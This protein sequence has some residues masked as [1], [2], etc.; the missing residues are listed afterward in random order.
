MKKII[1]IVWAIFIVIF[2]TSCSNASDE[3]SSNTDNANGQFTIDLSDISDVKF[4]GYD[5]YGKAEALISSDNLYLL[6]A[7]GGK[8]ENKLKYINF[9]KSIEGT[10]N[11]TEGLINGDNIELN[12]TYDDELAKQLNLIIKN[13]VQV[14]ETNGLTELTELSIGEAFNINFDGI[15][16]IGTLSITPRYHYI[17]SLEAIC[18]EYIKYSLFNNT[19]GNL[20]NGQEIIIKVQYDE[21]E[22]L[23]YGFIIKDDEATFIVEGLDEYMDIDLLTSNTIKLFDDEVLGEALKKDESSKIYKKFILTIKNPSEID[24]LW[25]TYNSMYYVFQ[26]DNNFLIY[27]VSTPKKLIDDSYYYKFID[28]REKFKTYEE[29]Y[30]NFLKPEEKIY[31]IVEF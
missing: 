17:N 29:L 22:L 16:P 25:Y 24:D 5:G 14:F 31:E 27:Y 15:S 30:E 3:G 4:S 8:E 10:L 23:K 11:I 6:D 19:I 7:T 20:K 28:Y 26:T 12:I 18:D 1:I 21:Q 2:I 13:T 9:I